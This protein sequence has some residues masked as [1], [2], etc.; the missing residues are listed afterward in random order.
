MTS[1]DLG[2]TSECL[3]VANDYLVVSCDFVIVM[4][5][6]RFM[7]SHYLVGTRKSFVVTA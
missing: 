7:A 3:V 4:R 1:D 2:L 6:I 5:Y